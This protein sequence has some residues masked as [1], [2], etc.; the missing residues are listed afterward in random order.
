M[1]IFLSYAWTIIDEERVVVFPY[2]LISLF[3]NFNS[4]NHKVYVFF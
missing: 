4:I 3:Y 1:H 2:H